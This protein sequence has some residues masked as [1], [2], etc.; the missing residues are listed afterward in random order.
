VNER[1]DW[2]GASKGAD[3]PAVDPQVGTADIARP[4]AGKEHDQVGDLLRCGEPARRRGTG[5]CSPDL[6]RGL[7]TRTGDRIRDPAVVE[8]HPGRHRSRADRVD[9]NVLRPQFF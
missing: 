1:N 2:A 3:E 4:V 6:F 7:T 5:R 8:L 9:A